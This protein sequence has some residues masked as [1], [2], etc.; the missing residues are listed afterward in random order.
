MVWEQR[1]ASQAGTS[2]LKS[3]AE[4]PISPQKQKSTRSLTLSVWFSFCQGH[5]CSPPSHPLSHSPQTPHLLSQL[6]QPSLPH[7]DDISV[8]FVALSILYVCPIS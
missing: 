2:K 5:S 7:Q 8:S 4:L 6:G 1:K 3:I